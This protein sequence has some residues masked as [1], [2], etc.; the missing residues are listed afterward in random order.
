[1]KTWFCTLVLL[2]A[3]VIFSFSVSGCVCFLLNQ[4]Q[5]LLARLDF[6][7]SLKLGDKLWSILCTCGVRWELVYWRTK[8]DANLT[9]TKSLLLMYFVSFKFPLKQQGL[10]PVS[11]EVLHSWLQKHPLCRKGLQN[12]LSWRFQIYSEEMEVRV[13]HASKIFK[14]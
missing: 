13:R 10:D 8:K 14:Q 5:D 4:Y 2:I 3:Q 1:M 9:G 12:S 11:F 6:M 7:V